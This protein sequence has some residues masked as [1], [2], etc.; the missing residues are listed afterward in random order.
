VNV[1]VL[2]A[3]AA[4][5]LGLADVMHR[6]IEQPFIRSYRDAGPAMRMPRLR[7]ALLWSAGVLVVVGGAVLLPRTSS[8]STV[9]R[10]LGRPDV[11]SYAAGG[12][13]DLV[14]LGDSH[15]Q[16]M[17]PAFRALT[18]D[19]IS[20]VDRTGSACFLS[21]DLIYVMRGTAEDRCHS[22]IKEQIAALERPSTRHRVLFMGMR[23]LAYLAPTLISRYD[24][25]AD[26]VRLGAR[27]FT[28]DRGA[29]QRAYL[30][31]L[32]A[33]VAKLELAHVPI[34]FLAPVPEMRVWTYECVYNNAKAECRVPRAEEEAY[35]GAFLDGLRAIT[36]RHPW[37]LIWDV[38]DR[39]CSPSECRS[40][41]DDGTPLYRDDDHLSIEAVGRTTADL[42][43]IVALAVAKMQSR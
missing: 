36:A 6:C 7:L 17:F 25:P 19:G 12:N 27:L 13:I 4:L 34:I 22:H 3:Y 21:E 15:A 32:E 33:T 35:R 11:T 39:I 1:V 38:A 9:A 20:I 29:A 30:A 5:T 40:V 10:R 23:S 41:A 43:G 28:P 31:S 18:V 42:R 2:G 24:V 8:A 16:Q 14:V 26:G 37:F